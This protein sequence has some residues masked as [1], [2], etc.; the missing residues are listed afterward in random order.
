MMFIFMFP[1]RKCNLDHERLAGEVGSRYTYT[2]VLTTCSIVDIMLF[3]QR[4]V[5]DIISGFLT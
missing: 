3:L 2:C 5:M 1:N 4:Q